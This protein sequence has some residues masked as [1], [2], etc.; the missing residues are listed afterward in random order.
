MRLLHRVVRILTDP[1]FTET[2]QAGEI[3][4]DLL[5]L[6]EGKGNVTFYPLGTPKFDSLTDPAG[7]YPMKWIRRVR[8]YKCTINIDMLG[9]T[10]TIEIPVNARAIVNGVD[11]D[12][13]NEGS[14]ICS[15]PRFSGQIQYDTGLMVGGSPYLIECSASVIFGD[16]SGQRQPTVGYLEDDGPYWT[17]MKLHWGA[18]FTG[19]THEG[20]SYPDPFAAP[21]STYILAGTFDGIPLDFE[22]L[23]LGAPTYLAHSVDFTITRYWQ[24]GTDDG[25]ENAIVDE[26]TGELLQSPFQSAQ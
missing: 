6:T 15:M 24:F 4:P 10:Y 26:T 11:A 23:S 19:P 5:D 14:A 7:P 1:F 25:G 18:F 12:A 22:V 9:G 13:P 8:Q 2:N 16:D 3:C 17:R 21:G 20:R